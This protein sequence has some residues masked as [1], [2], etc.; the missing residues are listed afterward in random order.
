MAWHEAGGGREIRSVIHEMTKE[1]RGERGER[2]RRLLGKEEGA[3]EGRA[4]VTPF[5]LTATN[6]SASI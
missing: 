3:E 4:R 5:F 2:L 6:E 1:G